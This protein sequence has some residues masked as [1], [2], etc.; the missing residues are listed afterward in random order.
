MQSSHLMKLLSLIFI[1]FS[2]NTWC[3]VVELN[4]D[5]HYTK[6]ETSTKQMKTKVVANIG[7]SFVVPARFGN[8]FEMKVTL[9]EINDKIIQFNGRIFLKENGVQ[10][11]IGSYS[12]VSEYQKWAKLKT[13]HEDGS[14]FEMKVLPKKL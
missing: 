14:V 4:L 5:S 10:K 11:E 12:V 9:S 8:P 6:G 7:N 13:I 1:L 3:N 2:F